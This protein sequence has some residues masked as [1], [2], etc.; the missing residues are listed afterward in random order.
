MPEISLTEPLLTDGGDEGNIDTGVSSPL[1]DN[2]KE[3]I[4][5]APHRLE[6]EPSDHSTSDAPTSASPPCH[7]TKHYCTY[8]SRELG[9]AKAKCC[10]FKKMGEQL[11]EMEDDLEK[12]IDEAKVAML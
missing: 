7:D 10:Q 2:V 11:D 4:E 5:N 8:C 3:A 9:R 12:R 6:Y 1:T